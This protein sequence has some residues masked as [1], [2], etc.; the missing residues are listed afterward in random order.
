M[1]VCVGWCRTPDHKEFSDVLYRSGTQLFTDRRQIAFT[2]FPLIIENADF[3][4]FVAIKAEA[5]F[6]QDRFG[7]AVLTDGNNRIECMGAGA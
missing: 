5:D 7:L 3:D 6:L 4:Q 2:N 1:F